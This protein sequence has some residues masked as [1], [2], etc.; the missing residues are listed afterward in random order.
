MDYF[1]GHH[2]RVFP[3]YPLLEER[4]GDHG[5][6]LRQ[7]EGARRPLVLRLAERLH[8]CVH[9]LDRLLLAV[10]LHHVAHQLGCELE[11]VP[12]GCVPAA[13]EEHALVDPLQP[14]VVLDLGEGRVWGTIQY[15]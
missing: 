4:Y 7:P 2:I 14:E 10:G 13:R 6:V 3:P 8:P 1:C 15:T 11:V 12:L 5:A 9:D